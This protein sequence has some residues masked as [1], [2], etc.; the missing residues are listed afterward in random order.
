[1]VLVTGASGHLGRSVIANLVRRMD[2][3]R[4]VALVREPRTDA[5]RE[6]AESGVRVCSGDYDDPP[7]LDAA[8]QG[9]ER[10]LLVSGTDEAHRVRQHGNVID[11]ATRAGVERIAYTSRA[12]RSAG[13]SENS[14]MDGHFRTE[15]LIR[16]S[17]LAHTIFRNALYLDTLPIF[18]GVAQVFETGIH[19]PVGHGRVSF[20]LRSELA[21]AIARVL[22]EPAADDQTLLLT[23][24]RAWSFHEIA[25]ALSEIAGRPVAYVDI[26]RATYE[27]NMRRRGLPDPV[28]E[29]IYGFYGDIRDGQLDEVSPELERL[30]GRRPAELREGLSQV[31]AR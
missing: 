1:V 26:D 29:R 27:A 17:G 13:T 4:I 23:A 30:L 12:L 5:A 24:H 8:M 7:S 9:V 6:L 11:A 15:D 14:L 31:F 25:S 3:R 2:A 21:E 20:A 16:A 28:I 10:V 19:L 22:H 18:V